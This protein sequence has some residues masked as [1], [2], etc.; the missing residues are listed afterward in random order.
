[1]TMNRKERT[2]PESSITAKIVI[3]MLPIDKYK[4]QAQGK[5]ENQWDMRS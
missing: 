4:N 1:M 5:W 3:A 2:N